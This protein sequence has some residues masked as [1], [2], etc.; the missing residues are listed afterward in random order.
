MSLNVAN[1][2]CADTCEHCNSKELEVLS[3]FIRDLDSVPAR[4]N[5][6]GYHVQCLSCEA[7]WDEYPEQE[8]EAET[9]TCECC[10][11]TAKSPYWFLYVHTIDD[12][13]SIECSEP[14]LGVSLTQ[15]IDTWLCW[16]CEVKLHEENY[17]SE[18]CLSQFE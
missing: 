2:G 15:D 17:D 5:P 12:P 10:K 16:D 9:H 3:K 6:V 18:Y 13:Y 7:F 4:N 8:P 14:E 1:T 11:T